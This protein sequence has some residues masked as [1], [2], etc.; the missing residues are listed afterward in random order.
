VEERS[1]FKKKTKVWWT[2]RECGYVHYGEE[3]PELCPSCSHPKSF[4]QLLNEEY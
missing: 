2:C 3:P 4:Y 1:Y